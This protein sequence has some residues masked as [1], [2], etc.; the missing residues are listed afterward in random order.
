MEKKKKKGFLIDD[1]NKAVPAYSDL[2]CSTYQ[3]SGDSGMHLSYNVCRVTESTIRYRYYLRTRLVTI[4]SAKVVSI[5]ILLKILANLTKYHQTK[6]QGTNKKEEVQDTTNRLRW[7]KMN[8]EGH[9]PA[10]ISARAMER[11]FKLYQTD[12]LWHNY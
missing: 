11:K 2:H 10:N 4:L 1:T 9:Q 12:S 8:A 3:H 5:Q 7:L 6:F